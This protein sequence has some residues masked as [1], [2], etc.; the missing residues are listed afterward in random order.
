LNYGSFRGRFD[1]GFRR[2]TQAL[3]RG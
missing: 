2:A 3:T 1:S